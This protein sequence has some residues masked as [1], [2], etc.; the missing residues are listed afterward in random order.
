MLL[1]LSWSVNTCLRVSLLLEIEGSLG[2]VWVDVGSVG[3][4]VG[5]LPFLLLWEFL[6][7]VEGGV[8]WLFVSSG[9]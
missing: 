2:T 8:D 9:W 6:S 3:V 5:S 4:L 7:L 1:E